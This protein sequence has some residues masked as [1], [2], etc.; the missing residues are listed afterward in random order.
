MDAPQQIKLRSGILWANRNQECLFTIND[1]SNSKFWNSIVLFNMK[2]W[3]KKEELLEGEVT[4]ESTSSTYYGSSYL[5]IK[6]ESIQ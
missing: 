6:K 4:L 2:Y 5:I 3:L 1:H